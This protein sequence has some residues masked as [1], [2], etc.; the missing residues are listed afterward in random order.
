MKPSSKRKRNAAELV[1]LE[2]EKAEQI[3][4][5]LQYQGE[6]KRLQRELDITQQQVINSQDEHNLLLSFY[7][8]GVIDK[9]RNPNVVRFNI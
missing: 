4:G 5:A 1:M 6:I 3:D 9:D 2:E 7:S 8:E